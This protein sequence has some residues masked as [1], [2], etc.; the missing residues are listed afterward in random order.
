MKDKHLLLNNLTFLFGILQIMA[1]LYIQ[2]EEQKHSH[3]LQGFHFPIKNIPVY[4]STL[5]MPHKAS[6]APDQ[7]HTQSQSH[8]QCLQTTL[9]LSYQPGHE[10]QI[11]LQSQSPFLTTTAYYELQQCNCWDCPKKPYKA[12]NSS[13]PLQQSVDD[14]ES[15][16][17]QPQT[18]QSTSNAASGIWSEAIWVFCEN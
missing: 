14:R 13:V 4:F 5:Q 17:K 1:N 10:Q 7:H 12:P 2:K 15:S 11:L 18:S 8:I 6:W 16:A 9:K 3:F